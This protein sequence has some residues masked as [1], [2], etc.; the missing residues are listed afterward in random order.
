[1]GRWQDRSSAMRTAVCQCP[2]S[3]TTSVLD[4]HSEKLDRTCS[5]WTR[6]EFGIFSTELRPTPL[7]GSHRIFGGLQSV[8]KL[9]SYGQKHLFCER[10]NVF[11]STF[12]VMSSLNS[13][14]SE[15]YC[16]KDV[17]MLDHTVCK[18]RDCVFQQSC[19]QSQAMWMRPVSYF[20]C[21]VLVLKRRNHAWNQQIRGYKRCAN[22]ELRLFLF[23]STGG[24]HSNSPGL[25]VRIFF[26]LQPKLDLPY[27]PSGSRLLEAVRNG[28]RPI[29]TQPSWAKNQK[30]VLFSGSGDGRHAAFSAIVWG[31]QWLT[32]DLI[33]SSLVISGVEVERHSDQLC[34]ATA[35][36]SNSP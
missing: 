12:L 11:S 9:T 29:Y 16:L 5:F 14:I 7:F 34:C 22:D 17:S 2:W 8:R 4:S 23:H 28:V 18:L 6:N 33:F 31:T 15:A 20:L 26:W 36:L 32:S 13:N 19:P 3:L 27:L 10:F 24:F 21:R 35:Q 1:M 30:R 25:V